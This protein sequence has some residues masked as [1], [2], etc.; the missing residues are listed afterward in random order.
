MNNEK[1]CKIFYGKN[2]SDYVVRNLTWD[3][4]KTG[5]LTEAKAFDVFF[6]DMILCNNYFKVG[7]FEDV[8]MLTENN[9]DVEEYQLFIVDL[10]YNEDVTIKAVEKMGNTLYYDSKLDLYILGVTDLGMSRN[11]ITT[12]LEVKE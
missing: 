5:F 10:V 12:N 7:G 9:E 3:D 2:E 4:M 8:D 11:F 1:F 6:S